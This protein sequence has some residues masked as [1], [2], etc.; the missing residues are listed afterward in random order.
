MEAGFIPIGMDHFARPED[1]LAVAAR[2]HGLHRNFQGYCTTGRAGQ[3]YA[4]GASAISQL[5]DGYIQNAKDLDRY[6]AAVNEGKLSHESAYRMRP[7]DKAVRN[8]INGL[9]CDGEARVGACLEAE[10]LAED[11]KGEYLQESLARLAPLVEDGLAVFAG[12][13]V[14]LTES[15]HYAS[16][17]VASAFDPMLKAQ[18]A[19]GMPRYSQ[20]L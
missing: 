10:G 13:A 20:T 12:D 9:L 16:R 3:V 19:Q 17:A 18:E 7:Q 8:I 4:L 6:L 2:T 15:G 11:W 5:D 14:R 1:E